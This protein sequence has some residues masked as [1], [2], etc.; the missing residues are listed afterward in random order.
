MG[1]GITDAQRAR[2]VERKL[3]FAYNAVKRAQAALQD[4]AELLEGERDAFTAKY[5]S[6]KARDIRS[7]LRVIDIPIIQMRV[8]WDGYARY[9]ARSEH[10]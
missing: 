5:E 9:R 1:V 8:N 7:A 6:E 3:D 2:K 10:P 4:A